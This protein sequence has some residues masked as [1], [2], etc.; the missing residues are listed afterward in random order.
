MGA[1]AVLNA[2][3]ACFLLWL[4]FVVSNDVSVRVLECTEAFDGLTD[5]EKL[6]AHYIGKASWEG[7]K[8]SAV[9]AHDGD[10]VC[11]WTYSTLFW[12]AAA[13]ICLLQCSWEA[14]GI[15]SLLQLVFSAQAAS[16]QTWAQV[17]EAAGVSSDDLTSFKTYVLPVRMMPHQRSFIFTPVA[18]R[19][20]WCWHWC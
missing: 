4:Q 11:S 16:E 2:G 13:Q 8:V 10:D 1:C 19:I 12:P 15:F 6:Y 9:C 14:P 5:Q 3:V 20:G 18:C 7:A 17:A